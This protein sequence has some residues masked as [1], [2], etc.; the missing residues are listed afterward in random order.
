MF[1]DVIKLIRNKCRRHDCQS[2]K[3]VMKISIEQPVFMNGHM[4]EAHIVERN[5]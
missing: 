2:C 5:G 4:K 3:G 1:M